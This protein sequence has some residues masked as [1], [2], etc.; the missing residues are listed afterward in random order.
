MYKRLIMLLMSGCLV[1]VGAAPPSIGIVK[2]AGD[3]RIDGSTIRGNSTVFDGNLIETT[4]ATSV[5]QLT[6]I[7]LTLS[8]ESRAKVY[9][10]HIVLELGTGLVRDAEKH[11]IEAASLRISSASP[12][13]LLQV[14]IAGTH[15][16]AVAARSGSVEVRNRAGVLIASIGA[17]MA[18]AFDPQAGAATAAKMTGVLVS[19]DG[20]FFVTDVTT[21]V[22]AEVHGTDLAKFAGKKVDITGSIIPNAT[23]AV[24]A[25]QVVQVTGIMDAVTA[26][27][28]AAGAAGAGAAGAGAAGGIGALA[29]VA[30]VGGV[31]VGGTVLGL[32]AA[33][34]FSSAPVSR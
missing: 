22:T 10:D 15:H 1:T 32:G 13:S 30:I 17:G 31:A 12:G 11:I 27:A 19:K 23:P 25:S 8:P 26:A 28:G 2:S 9:R 20:T 18:L 29:T 14:E 5:V 16:V 6:G 7:Q 4:S 33:G 34:T 3:F 24:G 21:N